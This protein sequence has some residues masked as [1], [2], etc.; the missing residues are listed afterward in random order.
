MNS[1]D[2]KAL[3]GPENLP[4]RAHGRT[5]QESPPLPYFPFGASLPPRE[6]RLEPR[7]HS[8]CSSANSCAV[9]ALSSLGIR[10]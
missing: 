9:T 2:R 8:R 4:P 7:G 3:A 6:K 10:W 5:E 1:K